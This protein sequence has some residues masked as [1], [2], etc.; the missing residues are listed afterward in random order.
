MNLTNLGWMP[1]LDE[2]FA[3]HAVE[4]LVPARVSVAYGA[5]FRVITAEGDYLADITGRMRHEAHG[6]RDLPA[7]GDW[8]AVKPTTIA[9]GRASIQAILPRAR[10]P[11][12]TRPSRSWRPTSTRRC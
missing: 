1:A 5:T 2:A 9:G 8:V 7:V 6:R 12:P 4:G 10:R 3:P 11:A